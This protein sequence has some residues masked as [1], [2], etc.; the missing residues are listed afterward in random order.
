MTFYIDLGIFWRSVTRLQDIINGLEYLLRYYKKW[1]IKSIAVPPLGCGYGQLEWRIVGP[2]LYRYLKRLEIP[3][4][5]YAPHGTSHEELQPEFLQQDVEYSNISQREP[6][7]Q[8]IRPAWVALVDIVRRLEDQPFHWPVGRTIFQKIAY[9]ATEEGLP[10]GLEYQKSSYGPFSK[11]LKNLIVKLLNNGLIQEERL[12]RMFKVS[13]GPTFADA[14]KEYAEKLQQWDH[15]L[16]K[17]TDLFMRMK[18]NQA[19]LVATALFTYKSL[20]RKTK[21]KYSELD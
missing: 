1:G 19:E 11:E 6:S 16:E 20:Q 5:L 4:E 17:T 9:V 18:T 15:L 3:V 14:Q 7:P 8:R 10:T 2:S 13:V 21:N 12:G